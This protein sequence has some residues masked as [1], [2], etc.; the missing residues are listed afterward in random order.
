MSQCNK[1]LVPSFYIKVFTKR[2]KKKNIVTY[3]LKEKTP[4][5]KINTDP[6][7]NRSITGEMVWSQKCSLFSKRTQAQG[8]APT[9]TSLNCIAALEY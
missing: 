6:S 2:K 5:N 8:P 9:C 7:K 3:L 1:I 4:S